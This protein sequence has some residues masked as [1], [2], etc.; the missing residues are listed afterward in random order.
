MRQGKRGFAPEGGHRVSGSAGRKPVGSEYEFKPH[1]KP[2][3]PAGPALPDHPMP[4]RIA[5][6]AVGLLI[7]ITSGLANGLLTA[8]LPQ[9]QGA[10]GI[11]PEQGGW[12]IA[13]YSMTNVCMALLLIKFRQQFGQR[14]FTRIML[15]GFLVLMGAQAFFRNYELELVVRAASGVVGSGLA[16]LAF[17]YMMQGLAPAVRMNAV[18]IGMG[19]AQIA[20]PFAT[21]ISPVLLHNGL[22][23]NLFLFEFGLTLLCYAAVSLLRL[24]PAETFVAFE[25]LDLL[26]F[27]LFA[28]GMGLLCAVLV[29]GRIEWWSTP[30]LGAALAAAIVLIAA[31]MLVE[32]F[33]ADPLLNTRWM[34]G[35]NIVRFALVA[36]L[37]R[38]L[39]SEQTYGSLGLLTAVGMSREQMVTLNAVIVAAS[40]AGLAFG[41]YVLRWRDFMWPVA[42]AAGL[43]AVGAFMDSDATNLTRPA[44][45]YISQALIAFAALLFLAPIVMVG[46]ARALAR[47]PNHIVSFAALFGATQTVG[48]LM[49]GAGLT[50]LQV[51]RE[52]YHS[53]V[54]AQSLTVTAPQVAARLQSLSG[55]N[56]RV[57]GDPAIRQAEGLASLAA[58][59]TREANILAYNDV[60]LVIAIAAAAVF[61]ILGLWWVTLRLRGIYLLADDLAA[62]QQARMESMQKPFAPGTL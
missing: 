17:F 60:F 44:S 34:L 7:S 46:I 15:L 5:Y 49:G 37:I 58:Q 21:A 20:L 2:A 14:R 54:L 51:V 12:L 27:A 26:T 23:Q 56:S 52:K 28:P 10:L 62:M 36:T 9:I 18:I 45:L 47:G 43:I 6:F 42:L 32:H 24:P 8:N 53:N 38:V 25:P 55:A 57:L 22:V 59:V 19:V 35:G 40:A 16:T 33:R 11:S 30:W 29:Q 61:V 4:R 39:L 50:T 41:I 13:A 3:V 31:A 48:G 1:E